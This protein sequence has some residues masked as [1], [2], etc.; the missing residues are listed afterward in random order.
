MEV[1]GRKDP[2]LRSGAVGISCIVTTP[3]DKVQPI[4]EYD[5]QD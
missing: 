4:V 3:T 1:K 2:S 5:R